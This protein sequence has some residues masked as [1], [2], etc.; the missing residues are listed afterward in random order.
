M[1]NGLDASNGLVKYPLR[2][3]VDYPLSR[4]DA[5]DV[6]TDEETRLADRIREAIKRSG[7]SQREIARRMG[8]SETS[9][10][11]WVR[12]KAPA[13]PG[14][15]HLVAFVRV[16]QCNGHWLVTG[17]GSPDLLVVAAIGIVPLP[18]HHS[19]AKQ[20]TPTPTGVHAVVAKLKP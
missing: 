11:Q 2:P 19:S 13:L 8:V 16:T 7:L 12:K 10:N 4:G 1:S 14:W 17:Q 15:T 3:T 20:E 5:V 18:E 6:G 9:V